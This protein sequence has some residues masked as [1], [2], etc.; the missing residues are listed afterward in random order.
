MVFLRSPGGI[1]HHPQESVLVS[2]VEAAYSAGLE[3]LRT[4]RDDTGALDF[5]VE[6]AARYAA[7]VRHA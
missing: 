4:F 5:L 7:E 3:F 6:N 2:D 1:S